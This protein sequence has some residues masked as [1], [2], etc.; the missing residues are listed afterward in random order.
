MKYSIEGEIDFYAELNS[1]SND[2]NIVKDACNND[3]SNESDG[4]NICN[5]NMQLMKMIPLIF[6]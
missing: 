6:V 5:A 1:L 2:V 4:N 3:D